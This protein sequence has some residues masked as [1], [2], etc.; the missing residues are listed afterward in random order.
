MSHLNEGEDLHLEAEKSITFKSGKKYI[1]MASIVNRCTTIIF[2]TLK[3]STNEKSNC[4]K[5]HNIKICTYKGSLQVTSE[6]LLN[7][8]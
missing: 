8:H 5:I 1:N 7:L 2:N 3:H 6:A 4:P